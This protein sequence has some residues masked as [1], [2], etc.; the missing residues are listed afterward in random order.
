MEIH[1]LNTFLQRILPT[2]KLPPFILIYP[3]KLF[4]IVFG[5]GLSNDAVSIIL[6]YA[7]N[8]LI[9]TKQGKEIVNF[10]P[11]TPLFLL[12]E[13][14]KNASLSIIFGL[15]FGVIASLLLKYSRFISERSVVETTMVFFL[16]FLS[17]MIA[18]LL[19][20]SG[21]ISI[22]VCGIFMSHYLFYNLSPTSQVATG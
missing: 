12:L 21:V 7:V 11:T 10:E 3:Y 17:Y 8:D 19:N 5:E 13:F 9:G 2:N 22:L 15:L 4:S 14:L 18:E 1:F 20:I 6:F 16:G